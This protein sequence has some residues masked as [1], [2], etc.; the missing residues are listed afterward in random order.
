MVGARASGEGAGREAVG[1]PE[2][3]PGLGPELAVQGL[4]LHLGGVSQVLRGARP[5][6]RLPLQVL[7]V[8]DKRC[9]YA[10]SDMLFR[11]HNICSLTKLNN[12]M[13]LCR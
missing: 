2:V 11:L 9:R 1:D 10:W 13:Y 4:S 8:R 7:R 12:N 3:S 5:A 6:A